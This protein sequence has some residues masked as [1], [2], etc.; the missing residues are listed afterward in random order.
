MIK[1]PFG[2]L[3]GL[4]PAV[5]LLSI[6]AGIAFTYFA[7][8]SVPIKLSYYHWK[9]TYRQLPKLLDSHP[10]HRLY[11]KF[12]DIGFREQL[13]LNPTR[14]VDP[15]PSGPEI[16]PVVYLDNRAL[17]ETAVEIVLEKI[18]QTI[19]A[20]Q[21][22]SLQID[23]DWSGKT[24]EK[25][26][27][28][29]RELQKSYETLSVT[30]RLHQ[31]KYAKQTGVPPA[32]YVALMYYNMSEVR[33]IDT[34]NYVLDHKIGKQYLQN[35]QQ[36]PLPM[37]LALPLY[38]QVRVIRQQ[39]VALLLSH[40]ELQKAKLKALSKRRFEVITA[41][42]WQGEYLYAGD[43]LVIDQVT[44]EQL[45]EASRDLAQ[46]LKPQEIIF[47]SYQDARRYPHEALQ[48]LSTLFD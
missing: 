41:H 16:V 6:V 34:Q 25:Y 48:N 30:L 9:N 8:P 40:G 29:L 27:R 28:L 15:L 20:K 36:Y 4:I 33:D 37:V 39:R 38:Q 2:G 14:F 24:R 13:Q 46:H 17:R 7:S 19:P 12:L 35:F 10:S 5:A 44:I 31:V 42:Y 26:F 21:Y 23:C 3:S 22:Q 1:K 18:L 43:E 11:I 47:Y 32:N 45:Q